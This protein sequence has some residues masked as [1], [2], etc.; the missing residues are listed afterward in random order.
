MQH[1]LQFHITTIR[2]MGSVR[3]GVFSINLLIHSYRFP[4]CI[5][6]TCIREIETTLINRSSVKNVTT[7][8]VHTLCDGLFSILPSVPVY[9]WSPTS[10]APTRC[11]IVHFGCCL[12][13]L[14]CMQHRCRY[15]F[16]SFWT[17]ERRQQIEK[18]T[19]VGSRCVNYFWYLM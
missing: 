2:W 14:Y 1:E 7:F 19:R 5:T 17:S 11:R 16:V 18:F 6:R 10:P 3:H 9:T 4:S 12:C 15:N 8:A 13:V